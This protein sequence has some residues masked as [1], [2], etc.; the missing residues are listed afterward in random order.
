MKEG[1]E[2][3]KALA[4][5]IRIAMLTTVSEN[6]KLRSRPMALNNIEEDGTMWFFTG[7]DSEKVEEIEEHA[8]VNVN[9]ADNSDYDYLSVAGKAE[10]VLDKAIIKE[11]FNRMTKAWFPEGTESDNIS[12][13]RV[14]PDSA[15][16]WDGGD[17]KMVQ[18]FHL[19]KALLTGKKYQGGRHETVKM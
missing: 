19:G 12:L 18:L 13:L 5:D 3:V 9:F 10:L 1:I 15:E 17:N 4:E 7:K 6:G 14:T 2:K 11:K 16:Y 8:K